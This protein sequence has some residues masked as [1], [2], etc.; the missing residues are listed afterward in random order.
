VEKIRSWLPRGDTLPDPMW[1][2]RHRWLLALA[3]LHVPVLLAI[4]FAAAYPVGHAVS[5][6]APVV[7]LAALATWHH[8]QRRWRAAACCLSLLSSSAMVVHIWHGQTEAHFHFFVVVTLCALYEEWLPYGLAFVYVF[9]HHALMGVLAPGQIYSHGGNPWLWAG[10]HGGF[11]AALGAANT[12]TWRLNEDARADTQQASAEFRSAFDDAPTG[13]VL[14]SLDGRIERVNQ[15]FLSITGHDARELVGAR[16]TGFVTAAG[17]GSDEVTFARSDGSTGWALW[18]ASTVHDADGEPTSHVVHMLD[19]S[20]RKAV[21]SE[22]DHQAHHDGLTGL[23][24]RTYFTDSLGEALAAGPATVLFVDLDEFKVVNDSL[25]HSAGDA[26]LVTVA[27]RLRAALRPGDTVARFGGDEFAILLPGV[28]DEELA[29]TVASRVAAAL[30][31]PFNVEG[32]ERYVTASVGL[33]CSPGGAMTPEEMLRDADAAM[34]RAKELGK[35][36]SAPFD[37]DL[38]AQV[39]QRMELEAD[40]R[41]AIARDELRLL[42]QPQVDLE[43]GRI[44]GVEALLRWEHPRAGT[45]APLAFIP[46]AERSGLIAR[47][48]AWVLRE[49]CAQAVAWPGVEMAVNV[50]PR[51]LA[52]PSFPTLVR[53]VLRET[54]LDPRRLC[55]EVTESCLISDPETARRALLELKGL[56]CKLAIDDFGVGQSS[57]G[58]LRTI[59]PIDTLKID[60]SFVD[61]LGRD[62]DGQ[63]IF[64]AVVQLARSLGVRAL[65]EGVET[66][67]QAL[68]IRSRHGCTVAQGYHFARPLT[69]GELERMMLDEPPAL[70]A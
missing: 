67:E 14:T 50:S 66:P 27:E 32:Q 24:N 22:L 42:Y 10:V 29:L 41:Y 56:H 58:Q 44:T 46:I 39:Q 48:G 8:P 68:A 34:Y 6:V 51:Q 38:R 3:W 1:A 69:A 28:D 70:A 26:L 40:L 2:R 53:R 52:D 60:R 20:G 33:R 31:A 36:R 5:H 65:A 43:T 4:S 25:G 64:D 13:M 61:G 49:A 11:I 9:A 12:V 59:L 54:G 21:E 45:I 55:L 30:D 17:D 7:A 63:A 57:L 37:A 35:D 62:D 47:V 15:T 16:L 18:R 23:P 19:I